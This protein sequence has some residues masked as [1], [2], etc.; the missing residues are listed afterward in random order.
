MI[1][2]TIP[3]IPNTEILPTNG[4][5]FPTHKIAVET[6][7]A[8]RISAKNKILKPSLYNIIGLRKVF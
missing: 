4:S 5:A 8:Q 7:L 3:I 1:L 6:I 2:I